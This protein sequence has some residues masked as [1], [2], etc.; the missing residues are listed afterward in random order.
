M[1]HKR[2]RIARD[3]ASLMKEV[4]EVPKTLDLVEGV[5]VSGYNEDERVTRRHVIMSPLL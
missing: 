1:K 3:H 5:Q 4:A 2:S